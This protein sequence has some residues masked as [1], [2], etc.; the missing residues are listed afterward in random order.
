M[1]HE[2]SV[3]TVEARAPAEVAPHRAAAR[4]LLT[5]ATL[6][7]VLWWN[8]PFAL[9]LW[10]GARLYAPLK[11]LVVGLV[12]FVLPGAAFVDRRRSDLGVVVYRVVA[13][14]VAASAAALLAVMALPGP[15]SR[16][17]FLLALAT[18]TNLG[19]WLGTR[20]G[21][22]LQQS[23]ATPLTRGLLL[24]S[25]LFYVQS[26]IAAAHV[27][28]ALEDQ[29]M[30]LQGTA[31][32]LVNELVPTMS[33]NQSS[34]Y[35]FAHPLLLHLLIGESVLVSGDLERLHYYHTGA[36]ALG[37]APPGKFE[38]EAFD[39][40]EAAVDARWA[41]DFQHFLRD[42]VLV[43][44]RTPNL[45]L[46]ALTLFPLGLLVFRLSG[47]A[48]AAWLAGLLYMTLP[49]VF[50]RSS[51]GGYM[52]LANFLGVSAAYFYLLAS[53]LLPERDLAAP[54]VAITHRYSLS[55]AFLGGWA[56]QK[57]VIVPI[58]ALG[59]AALRWVWPARDAVR[60]GSKLWARP[61]VRAAVVLVLGFALGW[62]TYMVYGVIVAKDMFIEHHIREHFLDRFRMEEVA[63]EE[64][65]GGW[66][67]PSVAGLWQQFASHSG[68]LVAAFG[69]GACVRAVRRIRE[70]EGM[71]LLW[72]AVAALGFSLIDWRQTKHFAQFLPALCALTGV[73][74]AA[75]S[76]KGR[77]VAN[78]LVLVA[79][80][81]NGWQIARLMQDFSAIQ[82]L[83]CW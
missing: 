63:P 73:L 76:G 33:T 13:A 36:V 24:L 23:F 80:A 72:I 1:L 2:P 9:A 47:S 3:A 57:F 26:Y 46:S 4:Q 66:V 20:R 59:H 18:L 17:V 29:D 27:V 19:L 50:V 78:A 28:P 39:I 41:A 34:R 52:A 54:R 64:A 79:I 25:A 40:W 12:L 22:Y 14:S 71:L 30:E 77:T 70:A 48:V 49:E 32:G 21:W 44:T 43:P 83:P 68:W 60:S 31:Y 38:G 42:P 65:P 69:A 61:D 74:W 45:F 5:R 82:P 55:A 15:T 81:W 10:P 56:D 62:I 67:Y 35:Y 16:T 11:P 58:A 53:G 6:W 51:Y 37:D 75:T 7:H 8:L